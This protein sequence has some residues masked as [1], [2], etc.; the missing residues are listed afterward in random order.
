MAL[1]YVW[2][3]FFMAAF[4]IGIAKWLIDGDATIFP[5]IVNST[6]DNAKA[7]FEISIGL[8]GVMTLWLGL[9]NIGEKAGFIKVLS[10]LIGPFFVRIFPEVPKDH[11]AMG[12]I[13][14]NYSANML[15]LDNA[16][17]PLGL[18]AMKE[19]QELNPNKETASNAQI[20][21]LVLNTAGFTIIP[22]SIIAYRTQ[23]KAAAPTDVFLPLLITTYAAT[24]IGLITVALYQ[25]INLFNKVIIA[26][27]SGLIGVLAAM[28]YLFKSMP[29][30]EMNRISGIVAN[31]IIFSIIIGFIVM[32]M[33]KKIN[34]YEAFIDGAK[35]GFGT[36]IKIIPYLVGML[37]AI[38][39]FRAAGGMDLITNCISD[40]IRYTG[41]NADFVP[42]LPTGLMKPFSGS[43]A[44]GLMLDC[45]KTSGVD[46]FAGKLACTFNGSSDTTFYILALYFGSVGIKNT[47]YALVPALVADIASIIISILLAYLFFR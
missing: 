19:L 5:A 8:T 37:V 33:I 24:T 23:M 39:V 46:S 38:G 45:M 15:G 21:F 14:M 4:V 40:V 34:V 35:E 7:A 16:A 22:I 13:M 43:G 25:K 17:T 47:R 3:F 26:Y 18:K 11:P 12:S 31:L 30:E 1:N 2:I 28:V 20:M 6:F 9:M 36:S 32:A 42:A 41:L 44:R 29:S 27:L 10:K